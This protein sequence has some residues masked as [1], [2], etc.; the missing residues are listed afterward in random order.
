MICKECPLGK[1]ILKVGNGITEQPYLTVVECPF[2]DEYYK[3]LNDD[4]DCESKRKKKLE[5]NEKI[6]TEKRTISVASEP[7]NLHWISMNERAPTQEDA[8]E[9]GYIIAYSEELG[10]YTVCKW[11]FVLDD[12]VTSHWMRIPKPPPKCANEDN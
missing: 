8:N 7:E 12:G 10:I 1:Q 6:Q 9:H 3:D 4:C 11:H 2:D 5:S